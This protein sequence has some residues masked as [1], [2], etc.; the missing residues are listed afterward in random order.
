MPRIHIANVIANLGPLNKMVRAVGS[1]VSSTGRG[2]KRAARAYQFHLKERFLRFAQGGGDWP[3]LGEDYRKR[4]G[5]K[6]IL[7]ITGDLYEGIKI[8]KSRSTKNPGYL[9]GYVRGEHHESSGMSIRALANIHQNE[10]I[11]RNDPPSPAKRKIIVLPNSAT[12]KA[13]TGFVQNG[14]N[15]DIVKAN[16]GV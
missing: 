3:A 7:I 10:G 9:V 5:S 4:K 13:M 11:V 12:R 6:V 2:L 14:I 15:Q 8:R 16:K 1:D